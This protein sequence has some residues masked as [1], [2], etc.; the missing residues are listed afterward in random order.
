MQHGKLALRGLVRESLYP[1][2]SSRRPAVPP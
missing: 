1:F 2:T